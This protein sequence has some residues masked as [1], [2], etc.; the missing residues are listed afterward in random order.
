M[1]SPPVSTDRAD[2]NGLVHQTNWWNEQIVYPPC[3]VNSY[4]H[5]HEAKMR[6]K[7]GNQILRLLSINS[8]HDAIPTEAATALA[9]LSWRRWAYKRCSGGNEDKTP[10]NYFP[11]QAE[12]YDLL[13][14]GHIWTEGSLVFCRQH[15]KTQLCIRPCSG[16]KGLSHLVTLFRCRSSAKTSQFG[17]IVNKSIFWN[18]L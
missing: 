14:L 4:A 16:D 2:G 8:M 12:D 1:E 17:Q 3:L 10:K 5:D 18:I 6:C 11:N 15:L 7:E 9:F 13:S